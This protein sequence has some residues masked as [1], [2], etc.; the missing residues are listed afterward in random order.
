LTG[1]GLGGGTRQVSLLRILD[2]LIHLRVGAE[3]T[4]S[5]RHGVG[6]WLRSLLQA[7][8]HMFHTDFHNLA[9]LDAARFRC[10]FFSLFG[11]FISPLTK[12]TE[13]AA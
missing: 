4:V 11:H 1:D 8:P 5:E 6:T 12:Q 2:N 10:R 9:L 7:L 3:E 13:K